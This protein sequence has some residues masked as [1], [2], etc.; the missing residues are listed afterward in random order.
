[1]TQQNLNPK[2]VQYPTADDIRPS[3]KERMPKDAGETF[4]MVVRKGP[5]SLK[6]I[7]DQTAIYSESE[8]FEHLS[9]LE[10]NSFLVSQEGDI[11]KHGTTRRV[12][13]VA[14]E[15]IQTPE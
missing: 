11:E 6:G 13:S 1:M 10:D 15:R 14:E 8:V 5:I 4:D 7:M 9:W 3:L 2:H 12:Y